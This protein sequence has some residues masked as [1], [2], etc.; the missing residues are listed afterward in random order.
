MGLYSGSV[1]PQPPHERNLW[2]GRT[3][4]LL[5]CQLRSY[6]IIRILLHSHTQYALGV[7]EGQS[8]CEVDYHQEC[9]DETLHTVAG[10]PTAAINSY[11]VWVLSL[12]ACDR[13]CLDT[14]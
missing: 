11:L 10:E 6:T 2:K 3:P 8:S 4:T 5:T 1:F 12:L 13:G 9:A 7:C 14:P